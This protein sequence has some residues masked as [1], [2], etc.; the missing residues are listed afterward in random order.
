MDSPSRHSDTLNFIVHFLHTNGLYAAEE[1]LVRELENRYPEVD[2]SSPTASLTAQMFHPGGGGAAEGTFAFGN[3]D[4]DAGAPAKSEGGSAI[5]ASRYVNC[6]TPLPARGL[7]MGNQPLITCT[8]RSH[9][10]K[11]CSN[12]Q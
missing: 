3:T 11:L 5:K 9:L 2:G 12:V 1:A 6:T 10:K 7:S 8:S 4:P